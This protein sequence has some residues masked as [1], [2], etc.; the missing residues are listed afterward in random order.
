MSNLTDRIAVVLQTEATSD[1][2]AGT[3]DEARAELEAVNEA[4]AHAKAKVLDPFSTSATV[5]KAKREFDDLTLQASRLGTALDCL[6]NQL[7]T[8]R[9]REAQ[10]AAV[11][12]YEE[13]KAERDALVEDIRRIYPEAAAKIAALLPRIEAADKKIVAA[14]NDLPDGAAW[15]EYPEQ[16]A[17]GRPP[18]EG[19]SL[20]R[21]VKL[22]GLQHPSSEW[23]SIW[24]VAKTR[25]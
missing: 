11:K 3:L 17:R 25:Q 5:T 20:A 2:L 8:A 13:A 15:L 6:A 18:H 1:A 19:S 12:L 10:A 7:E 21:S 14:N 9:A 23:N 22:P 16:I 4:C 24:P